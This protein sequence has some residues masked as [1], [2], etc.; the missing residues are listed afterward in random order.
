MTSIPDA[1]SQSKLWHRLLASEQAS[2]S[3]RGW[4]DLSSLS[5]AEVE[6][7][8]YVAWISFEAHDDGD[9]ML[10]LF[11]CWV[12]WYQRSRATPSLVIDCL[13]GSACD[14]A[15]RSNLPN[16][17]LNNYAKGS[18]T[19]FHKP[20]VVYQ[21]AYYHRILSIMQDT[22]LDV[23]HSDIDAL[24]VRNVDD[25]V[26]NVTSNNPDADLVFSID[27]G[28]PYELGKDWGFTLCNGF[29]LYRNTKATLDL[30]HAI[31]LDHVTLDN[32][33]QTVMN[34]KLQSLGCEWLSDQ[35]LIKGRC[36][37]VKIAVLWES[38]VGRKKELS[39]ADTNVVLHPF[40]HGNT[41]M[42]ALR[43]A[44]LCPK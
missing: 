17:Q 14:H 19:L 3:D 1:G 4:M 31:K 39:P 44:G 20:S 7:P 18:P 41:K 43:E 15:E 38:I 24:W 9:D 22:H 8:S 36:G 10:D 34:R 33:D 40:I 42:P 6:K 37:D 32:N 26:Q 13:S 29:V 12:D 11:D 27:H 23:L 30:L 28:I 35:T 16:M 21:Q 2:S 5:K 25:L